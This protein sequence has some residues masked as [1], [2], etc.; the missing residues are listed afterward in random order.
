MSTLGGL[1]MRND[2]GEESRGGA[3]RHDE[4]VSPGQSDEQLPRWKRP[5]AD[6]LEGFPEDCSQYPGS[7][8]IPG[9]RRA[10]P[11]SR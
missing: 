6:P 2:A 1:L 9:I 8:D 10:Y 7:H 4:G 11:R 3:L 5:G